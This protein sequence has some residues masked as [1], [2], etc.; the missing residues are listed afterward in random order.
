MKSEFNLI[1]EPWIMVMRLDCEIET[2]SIKTLFEKAHQYKRL[3]GEMPAQD[4]AIL[5]LLIA[6]LYSVFSRVDIDG[7][8]CEIEDEEDALERWKNIWDLKHFPIKPIE[9]YLKQYHNR[10]YLID[11]KKPFYQIPEAN[12]GTYYNASKLMAHISEGNN[13]TR[14]FSERNGKDKRKLDY[15]EATRWLIYINAYDDASAKKSKEYKKNNKDSSSKSPGVC[16]CGKLGNIEAV[17]E[18]LYQVLLLNLTF[19]KD[20][21]DVWEPIQN[22]FRHCAAWEL[23]NP[24]KGERCEIITPANPAALLTLQSRRI[25]LD[26]QSQ[27]IVGYHVLSGDFFEPE[28]AFEEQMTIWGSKEDKKKTI[29]YPRRY[30]ISKRSWRE[31][32][33][34]NVDTSARV[35]GIVNWIFRLM[36]ENILS[37]NDNVHFKNI[38]IYYDSNSSSIV[39]TYYDELSFHKLLLD[40]VGKKWRTW[41]ENEIKNCEICANE[42]GKLEQ[43]IMLASGISEADINNKPQTNK[44][45]FFNRIDLS[46]RKWIFQLDPS[47][48]D[49]KYVNVLR[50]IVRE[51]AL[52][53]GKEMVDQIKD[54]Q[55]LYGR[56]IVEE[57]NNKKKVRNCS[58]L[59]SYEKFKKGIWS[60]TKELSNE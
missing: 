2:V 13:K 55:A 31:F 59:D 36:Q 8:E 58:V 41:I 15:A 26:I 34:L 6:I 54:I 18:N 43:K 17:G 37:K 9:D 56:K 40:N 60:T 12:I 50:K 35:P 51:K 30:N 22:D 44:E 25:L 49:E 1:D 11:D 28:N 21:I 57:K 23:D 29:I 53:I 14:I 48:D 39:N 19:L 42:I 52:K 7:E 24:R 33:S 32:S 38:S 16:W 46:V 10:F 3:A 45:L 27:K 20:G 4:N 47:S 5:R